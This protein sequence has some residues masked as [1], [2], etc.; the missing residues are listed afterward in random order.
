MKDEKRYMAKSTLKEVYGLTDRLIKLI[1]L[2]DKTAPNPYYNRAAPMCLYLIERVENWIENHPDEVKTAKARSNRGKRVSGAKR[3]EM[4]AWAENVDVAIYKL[5]NKKKLERQTLAASSHLEDFT[6][7]EN[8]IIA[9]VRHNRT[10]YHDLLSDLSGRAGCAEAYAIIR[11]RVNYEITK[12]L[13]EVG[14]DAQSR[15]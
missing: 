3:L 7:T 8:A 1:G 12:K 2:P 13:R 4:L 6:L 15:S 9:F 5:G 11:R 10:N 14:N